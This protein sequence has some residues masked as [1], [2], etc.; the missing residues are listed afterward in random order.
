MTRKTFISGEG[1][2]MGTYPD[3]YY[4]SSYLSP[5]SFNNSWFLLMLRLMLIA[6]TEDDNGI[7]N[8]LHLAFST[9]RAWLE[10]GKQI[11]VANA[12]TMFGK[13]DYTID[14]DIDNGKVRATVQMPE[15]AGAASGIS[16]R[17]RVP[18]KKAIKN[19]TV[20]GKSQRA[21]NSTDETVDL[22]GKTGRLDIIVH[23]N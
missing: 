11:K 14:S 5:T 12:P 8:R 10:Q 16:L 20:N 18:G 2:T 13:L 3:E 7:P 1:D 22:S 15:G 9:P 4:R 6:E 17:L 19:V 23:Y 21:F